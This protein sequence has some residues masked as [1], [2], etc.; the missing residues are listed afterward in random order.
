MT[1]NGVSV[2]ILNVYMYTMMMMNTRMNECFIFMLTRTL[3]VHK[4]MIKRKCRSYDLDSFFFLS[5]LLIHF[6]RH[7]WLV[8]GEQVMMI[9]TNGICT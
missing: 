7:N 8:I 2:G 6:L 1:I 5:F 9:G 4:F 3:N